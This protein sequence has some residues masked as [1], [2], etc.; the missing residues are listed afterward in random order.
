MPNILIIEDERAI[1]ESLEFVLQNEGFITQWKTLGIEGAELVE[2]S[3]I[4]LVILDIGLPDITGFEVCKRIRQSSQ[5]PIIF[6]SARGDELDRVVGLEIGADDYVVK[7]FSPREVAARVK[8]ILKRIQPI[9]ASQNLTNPKLFKI[10][11]NGKTIS[12]ND[13]LL[14]LTK[15]EYLLLAHLLENSGQVLSRGQLLNAVSN[16]HHD[17]YERTVDS[18]IKAIRSK[19]RDIKAP[20]KLIS[21]V[22]GFGYRFEGD[23]CH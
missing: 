20:E 2:R 5:V 22:R 18:H 1:A 21:T 10:H 3:T 4:D 6:L 11:K 15:A 23:S 12:Y 16:S 14:D 17:V 8:A 13:Q 7:P 9:D 19:L